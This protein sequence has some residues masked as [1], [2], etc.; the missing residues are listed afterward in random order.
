MSSAGRASRNR[1]TKTGTSDG[2]SALTS[3]LESDEKCPRGHSELSRRGNCKVCSNRAVEC[4][5]NDFGCIHPEL[6]SEWRSDR[7][8]HS[9]YSRSNLN[10]EWECSLGHRWLATPRNRSLGTGCQRCSVDKVKASKLAKRK[11]SSILSTLAFTLA[12]PN[13]AERLT[14]SSH[15][16]TDWLCSYGHR[17]RCSPNRISTVKCPVCLNKQLEPGSNDLGTVRPDLVDELEDPR[18]SELLVNSKVEVVWKRE[19]TEGVIHRWHATVESRAIGGSSCKIC[20]G[21]EVQIGVNDFQLTLDK[22]VEGGAKLKWSEAND[23]GPSEITTGSNKIVVLECSAHTP[24]NTIA[25]SAK[26]FSSG[27]RVCFDC[28]PSNERFVSRGENEVANFVRSLLPNACIERSVRRFAGRGVSEIDILVDGYLAI[29]YN[30]TYWH[31]EGVFKPVGFHESKSRA[32][33][34]LGLK[35]FIVE[36]E[37]WERRRESVKQELM[38][39]IC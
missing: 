6:L 26:S 13:D 3:M 4:G 39:L 2:G 16:E 30:G 7:D 37:E 21:L 5:F 18:N 11:L 8:P 36:E 35:E 17:F 1:L 31:Q 10:L 12:N 33:K 29:D 27:G 28:K 23:F 9:V 20:R 38:S 25:S 14:P 34:A 22:L 32:L 24:V 15:S 19:C